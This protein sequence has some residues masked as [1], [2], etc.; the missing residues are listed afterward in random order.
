MKAK[1]LLKGAVALTIAAYAARLA[2]LVAAD[3]QRYNRIRAMSD[4]P[5]FSADLP[6]LAAKTFAEERE[7][8]GEFAALAMNA[9]YEFLRYLRAESM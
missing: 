6:K 9:P 1:S 4:E 3:W 2:I 8:V 7:T 5:P